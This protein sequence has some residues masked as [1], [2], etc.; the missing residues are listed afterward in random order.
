[1]SFSTS[2]LAQDGTIRGK[3]LPIDSNAT[4]YL[5]HSNQRNASLR[6]AAFDT[7]ND[8]GEY[9]ITAPFG[10]Y[11]LEIIAKGNYTNRSLMH[12]GVKENQ[13]TEI[14]DI[15]LSKIGE[16]GSISGYVNPV[17]EGV[18]VRIKKFGATEFDAFDIV[19][20]DGSYKIT[21]LEPGI[22]GLFVSFNEIQDFYEYRWGMIDIV[23]NT[24]LSGI[25]LTFTPKT[26][27]YFIDRITIR[28]N[29]GVSEEGKIDVIQSYDSTLMSHYIASPIYV[30]N[31]PPTKT[32][33]EMV[34]L[35]KTNSKVK[36]AFRSEILYVA[37][38]T[39]TLNDT[40]SEVLL[41][42]ELGDNETILN[43]AASKFY[44]G[45]K[46]NTKRRDR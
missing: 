31:I 6:I 13:V 38:T 12:I 21:D 35:F 43:D 11:D 10:I 22:Y 24:K 3:V 18:A 23:A 4:V 20:D 33:E 14:Q 19:A 5:I 34:E 25:N 42:E 32:V 1:M 27:S 40:P 29:A 37:A 45:R 39:T 8:G 2:I 44:I 17:V 7:I 26:S 15:K 16:T 30:V 9:S 36:S 41:E 46:F 28:F